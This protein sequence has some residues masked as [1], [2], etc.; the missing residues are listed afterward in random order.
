MTSNKQRVADISWTPVFVLAAIGVVALCVISSVSQYTY[1][2]EVKA[3]MEHGYQQE[4]VG[5]RPV[6]KKIDTP[7]DSDA[8]R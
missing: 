6:W 7:G 3:A 8:E 1:Y 4:L 2:L 5:L